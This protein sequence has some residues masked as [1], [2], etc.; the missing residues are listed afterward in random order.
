MPEDTGLLAPPNDPAALAAVLR[1]MVEDAGL[2]RRCWAAARARVAN[3]LD[4]GT[5]GRET[6]AVYRSLLAEP[7]ERT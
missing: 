1:R 3:G 2:R 4:A 6:V 7:N 5:V